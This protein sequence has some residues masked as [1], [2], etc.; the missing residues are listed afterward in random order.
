MRIA[1]ARDKDQLDRIIIFMNV[2]IYLYSETY[3]YKRPDRQKMKDKLKRLTKIARRRNKVDEIVNH[4]TNVK[5]VKQMTSIDKQRLS[6][7]S[8]DDQNLWSRDCQN[9]GEDKKR[10]PQQFLSIEELQK[11]GY[12][13]NESLGEFK[14][15]H[16]EKKIMVDADGKTD[17]NKKKHEAI[18]RAIKLP[19]D[20]SGENFIYYTCGPEENGKHMYIGF[21]KS[22]NPY[23]DAKPCCF[24]KD[25][26]FLK[27]KKK[28]FLFEKHWDYARRR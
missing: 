12:V 22:K 4:E 27:T 15:G 13:W 14:F 11:I 3:L 2:L 28:E 21:L 25:H 20:D 7:K 1:G 16:Y 9:S 23:G 19:L 8:E 10:R 24:I 18:L 17:S 5:S 6:H 26:F